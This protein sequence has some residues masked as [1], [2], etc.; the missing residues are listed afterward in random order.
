MAGRVQQGKLPMKL[1]SPKQ[2]ETPIVQEILAALDHRK[3][4][5]FW[6]NNNAGIFDRKRNA[7]IRPSGKYAIKGVSDILGVSRGRFIAIEVKTLVEFKWYEKFSQN[8]RGIKVGE[9]NKKQLHALNQINFLNKVNE[10][11]GIGFFS[12]SWEHTIKKMEDI[13]GKN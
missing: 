12:H 8:M 13:N 4:G 1:L 5:F 9:L 10:N 11:G 2:N 7:Y 6:R 3:I